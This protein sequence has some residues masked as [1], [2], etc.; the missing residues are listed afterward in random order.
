MLPP[1]G[2]APCGALSRAERVPLDRAPQFRA[3][4]SEPGLRFQRGLRYESACRGGIAAW[5]DA[6]GVGVEF[7]PWFRFMGDNDLLGRKGLGWRF[8]Q[9][10][11]VLD[12]GPLRP[13][14]IVELKLQFE[15]RAWWQLRELYAPVVARA[16]GRAV[17][18]AAVVGSYDPAVGARV[19][20]RVHLA[21][22]APGAWLA[23]RLADE[24]ADAGALEVLQWK[25]P[26][27]DS[28]D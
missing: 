1:S 11:V 26:G 22:S 2:F 5:A 8:C 18:T 28:L 9:P 16:T 17:A 10:D 21:L 27:A 3:P 20:G 12:P 6:A 24:W 25:R 14:L 7:G 19:P 4:P 13:L 23:R 15:P